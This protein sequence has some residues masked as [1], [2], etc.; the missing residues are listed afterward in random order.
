MA[1][2]YCTFLLGRAYDLGSYSSLYTRTSGRVRT[3]GSVIQVYA[4]L[5][6][7]VSFLT[8]GARMTRVFLRSGRWFLDSLD[9]FGWRRVCIC[10]LLVWRCLLSRPS[11]S[12]IC[13][14]GR[15][16]SALYSLLIL[17]WGG[18]GGR[19]G[20]QANSGYHL[21]SSCSF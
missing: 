4:C 20:L 21:L 8:N 3:S 5:C 12:R 14:L 11:S 18:G 9:T 15:G 7:C 10:A 19:G 1:S 16:C 6:I 17:I 13:R 2:I